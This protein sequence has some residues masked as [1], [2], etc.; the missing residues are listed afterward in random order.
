MSVHVEILDEADG[1]E[2]LP[3]R[4]AI[5]DRIIQTAASAS[6][7][8]LHADADVSLL[9]CDDER[10]RELN[11]SFRGIDKPT[12]VL[13]F[14]GSNPN[15]LLLMLGDIAIAFETVQREARDEGKSLADHTA[16]MVAHGFLHLLGF[17][18]ENDED[19]EE[20]EAL[21]R[22][23]LAAHGIADP[24]GPEIETGD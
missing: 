8:K 13:S 16:H 19:A 21:E 17:D 4:H 22:A 2:A 9:F 5:A 3:D 14:P 23:I 15:G 1:W 6:K 12:N 7:S 24:Y 18:H 20:M 10:I 11:R